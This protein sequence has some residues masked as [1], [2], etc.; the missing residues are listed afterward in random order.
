MKRFTQKHGDNQ[1]LSACFSL[2]LNSDRQRELDALY[3]STSGLPSLVLMEQAGSAIAERIVLTVSEDEEFLVVC[4]YGQNAGDGWVVARQLNAYGLSCRVVDLTEGRELKGDAEI[5]RLAYRKLKL[6]ELTIS[7]LAEYFSQVRKLI[8]VEAIFGIGYDSERKVPAEVESTCRLINEHREKICSLIAIDLVGGCDDDGRIADFALAADRVITLGAFKIAALE[9]ETSQYN[10][11]QELCPLSMDTDLRQKLILSKDP[12][13]YQGI[14]Y[15]SDKTLAQKLMPALAPNAHKGTTGRALLIAGSKDMYGAELLAI[16]ACLHTPV[17]YVH[18]YAADERQFELILS[19]YPQCLINGPDSISSQLSAVEAVAIGSGS[20]NDVHLAQNIDHALKAD[21]PLIMDA[22]ALNH[23]AKQEDYTEKLRQAVAHRLA[24]RLAEDKSDSSTCSEISDKSVNQETTKILNKIDKHS[25]PAEIVLT[26][27]PGEFKR[28]APDL[29]LRQ[30]QR[31]AF[32]LA[33][34]THCIVVLKG[35]RTLIVIPYFSA[36]GEWLGN[37]IFINLSGNQELARAGS[38]DTLTGMM[39]GYT[40][41]MHIADAA[42]LSVYLH[43]SVADNSLLTEGSN[44]L[45]INEI[46]NNLHKQIEIIQG[47]C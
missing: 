36:T 40:T 39:L 45:L 12:H 27:H 18:A 47:G 32:E 15:L 8:V 4:G 10:Q 41:C 21:C 38:G 29:D 6:P 34:R 5:N 17:G 24:I 23:L 42:L 14:V 35:Y 26:P 11:K 2:A 9:P 30:R 20:A 16:N 46:P 3:Y 43:G 1:S 37:R 13:Q 7:E 25:H 19:T 33:R 31:A 22:D 28:L 44:A